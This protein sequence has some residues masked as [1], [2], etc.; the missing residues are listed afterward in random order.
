M[1]LA[2]GSGAPL[3][4]R[5]AAGATDARATGLP[6]AAQKRACVTSDAP[7]LLQLAMGLSFPRRLL[8]GT[9]PP[10]YAR[11]G[12]TQ[13]HDGGAERGGG[14]DG[15]SRITQREDPLA[16]HDAAEPKRIDPHLLQAERLASMGT[17]AGAIAHEVNGPLGF[18]LA[19]LAF[20]L[21]ELRQMDT[22]LAPAEGE[23]GPGLEARLAGVRGRLQT[24]VDSLQEARQGSDIVRLLV[25]DLKTFSGPDG[26]R[27]VPVD[28]RRV[29]E[30]SINMAY[31]SIHHR[32]RLVKDYRSS[33]TVD[34]NEARLAQVFLNL[35]V[36]AAEAIREGDPDHQEIR[37][38]LRAGPAGRCVVEVSD[39]GH[40]IAPEHLAA[41]FDPYFSTKPGSGIGLGLSICRT[42]V[43]GLGGEIT[44][45]SG[46]ATGTTFRVML[47]I[48]RE[49]ASP[50][51]PPRA[52]MRPTARRARVLVLDDEPMMARAVHRLLAAD[53]DVEAMTDPVKAV[54]RLR[55]GARFDVILCDLMMPSLAG[56][57]VYDAVLAID[58]EQARSMVF[59]S[60]GAY[61]QRAADFLER[62]DNPHLEKPLDRAALHAVLRGQ[63]TIA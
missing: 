45:E 47:P 8:A 7:H 15:E 33:P 41:V 37:V 16:A 61:T 30:S 60:G 14:A 53:Y 48:A 57:D 54:E 20:A 21:E 3:R 35:F 29:L 12:V 17:L 25:R 36:N 58:A 28:L 6:H 59:M 22:Q 27:A 38:V 39:T 40:G 55:A 32:A 24:V 56:M 42:V 19:N 63:L 13:Q 52:S 31:H 23:L 34:G 4:G 5:G 2:Y 50:V 9:E 1:V 44:V 62:A 10:E 46:L 11:R 51:P 18:T 43:T 26:A 49:T